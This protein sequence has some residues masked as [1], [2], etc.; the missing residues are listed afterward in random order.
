[1]MQPHN[2]VNIV[3]HKASP[4]HITSHWQLN[5]LHA[6]LTLQLRY[7]AFH[8]PAQLIVQGCHGIKIEQAD[9]GRSINQAATIGF[10]T[11]LAYSAR[12]S[13]T[14][15]AY[16]L[17]KRELL[18]DNFSGEKRFYIYQEMPY[19]GKKSGFPKRGLEGVT[20]LFLKVFGV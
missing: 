14:F 1:M 19:S 4:I 15:L 20:D 11:N 13:E 9:S 18:N 12:R 10:S 16:L 5:S 7:L 2:L 17:G 6:W 3:Q 8:G